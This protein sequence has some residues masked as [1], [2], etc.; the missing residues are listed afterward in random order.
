MKISTGVDFDKMIKLG[1]F[2]EELVGK[3]GDSYILKSK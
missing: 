3:K 2:I 1:K